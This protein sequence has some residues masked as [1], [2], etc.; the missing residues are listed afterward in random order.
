MARLHGCCVG[1][2]FVWLGVW[3]GVWSCLQV[4]GLGFDFA[5]AV[6]LLFDVSYFVV[7]VLV[8]G[9]GFELRFIVFGVGG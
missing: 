2:C 8:A 6:A 3:F 5:V 1:C 9:G 4:A 7:L